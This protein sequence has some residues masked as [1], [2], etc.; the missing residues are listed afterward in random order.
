MYLY[1]NLEAIY[2]NFSPRDDGSSKACIFLFCFSCILY[3]AGAIWF[4]F[5]DSNFK[6]EMKAKVVMMKLGSKKD[7]LFLELFEGRGS[8]MKC[9]QFDMLKVVS[10]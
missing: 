6:K 1:A 7:G 5:T 3:G 2:C 8:V 9:I 4:H 10:C